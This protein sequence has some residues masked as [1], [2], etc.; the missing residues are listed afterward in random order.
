MKNPRLKYSRFWQKSQ[1][2]QNGDLVQDFRILLEDAQRLRVQ[3][4][5]YCSG[6]SLTVCGRIAPARSGGQAPTRSM[7]GGRR[8]HSCRCGSGSVV[9][10]R[11][12]DICRSAAP[13]C[14]RLL[15]ATP[16]VFWWVVVGV[17]PVRSSGGDLSYHCCTLSDAHRLRLFTTRSER[18]QKQND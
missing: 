13:W 10:L 3:R 1:A 15:R 8:P 11:C 6:G 2:A 18:T 9:A 7:R 12:G 16:S 4:L 14:P 17:A 5:T